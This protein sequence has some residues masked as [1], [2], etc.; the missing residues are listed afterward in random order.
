L[1]RSRLCTVRWALLGICLLVALGGGLAEAVERGRAVRPLKRY[2][3]TESHMGTYFTIILYAPSEEAARSAFRAAFARV[4]E[5]DRILS[6]YNPDSELNRLCAQAGRGPVV[7]SE[8][9]YRV[10]EESVRVARISGGAFDVTVRPVVRLWRRARRQK[11]F[12]DPNRLRAARKLVGYDK[13]VLYPEKRAVQLR[14]PGMQIDLGGIGKGYALDQA[15]EVLKNRGI[16]S[17]LVDGGGDI[18]VSAPPPGRA[19]W[20]IAVPMPAST[21][22]TYLVLAHTA[23]A[24]SG[25]AERFVVLNGVRYSHIVDPR[26]GIAVKGPRQVSVVHSRAMTADALATALSVFGPQDALAF[27][28]KHDLAAQVVAEQDGRYAVLRSPA[29]DRLLCR[30][31][32]V[33]QRLQRSTER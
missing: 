22:P 24:T 5:L 3:Q 12:P 4:A 17:A 21:E 23:V 13:I 9:L 7:V 8:H 10:L 29:F 33:L 11:R 19:G 2:Q 18:A 1:E 16:E 20:I 31:R 32:R 26:T 14:Q 25:D 28:R 6:D 27:A 15:I 30:S